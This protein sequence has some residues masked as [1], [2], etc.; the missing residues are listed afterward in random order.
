[1]ELLIGEKAGKTLKDFIEDRLENTEQ[2]LQMLKL[3]YPDYFQILQKRYLNHVALRL[4]ESDY[5]QLR[6]ETV[7]SGEVFKNLEED[8]QVRIQKIQPRPTLDLHQ[9]PEELVRGV[10]LFSSIP[11]DR[12]SHISRLLKPML[13]VPGELI[14]KQGDIGHAMYFIASGCVEVEMPPTPVRLGSGDFFGEIALIKKYPRTFSVKSL[15]FS[16]LLVLSD[17]DFNL[18]LENNLEIRKILSETADKRIEMDGLS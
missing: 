10:P 9:D 3:Q 14:V 18:F 15:G 16:D 11:P 1:M 6:E 7:I 8:L 17:S 12:L 2:A 4:Q 5:E 13:T